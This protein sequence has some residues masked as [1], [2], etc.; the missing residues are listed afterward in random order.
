MPVLTPTTVVGYLVARGLLESPVGV[1]VSELTG[2]VSCRV[3]SASAPTARVV[4]K[5]ALPR[6]RV[7]AE[8]LADP[9][10]SG[11]EAAALRLLAGLTPDAV[12]RLLDDD[13]DNHA[14]TMTAAP[15]HWQTW[16]QQLLA[17]QVDLDVA[18]RLGQVLSRWHEATQDV[19]ALDARFA[20]PTGFRELR[21]SPFLETARDNHPEVASELDDVIAQVLADRRCLV[22]GDFTPKNVLVGDGR[23]WV[24]DPE[25]AHVGHPGFDLALLLAHLLLKAVHLPE[26]AVSLHRAAD[27]FLVGYGSPDESPLLPLLGSLLLARVDG[28][29]PAGYLTGPEKTRVRRIGA[30]LLRLEIPS[31]ADAFA[32]GS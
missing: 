12:P 5:Q 22:H 24:L 8:W 9:R 31:V 16:K 21:V 32:V 17:G 18:C 2:G 11:V 27:A 14:L 30:S 23:L 25:I 1:V 15:E 26:H 7:Q 20:N 13:E 10:R 6:L 4:V 28:K 29:S 3:Y 19:R